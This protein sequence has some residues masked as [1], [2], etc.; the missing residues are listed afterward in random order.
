MHT[1]LQYS[2]TLSDASI[3]GS[4]TVGIDLGKWN[5][6]SSG[7]CIAALWISAHYKWVFIYLPYID[8][9][10]LFIISSVA[11]CQA[12]LVLLTGLIKLHFLVEKN[13][14]LTAGHRSNPLPRILI[15][16]EAIKSH[17]DRILGCNWIFGSC[18]TCIQIFRIDRLY[19]GS[20]P[21]IPALLVDPLHG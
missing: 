4:Y 11:H 16:K 7:N 13:G 3:F 19:T 12:K 20:K 8:T 14:M 9:L 2:V 1:Y 6:Q 17:A 21:H 18:E 5:D 15:S 10:V